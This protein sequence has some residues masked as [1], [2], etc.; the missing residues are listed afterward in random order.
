MVCRI[1]NR[2][3]W[4]R[5]AGFTLLELLV[6]IAIIAVLAGVLLP[7][8]GKAK[9]QAKKVNEISSARQLMLAW[10]MY[11]GDHGDRVIRGYKHFAAGE[12][13]PVDRSGNPVPHPINSRYPW[14][15][16][17][18]LGKSFGVMYA[19]ENAGL[20]RQFEAMPDSF[21]GTYAAS[22]FPSLGINATFVG[23]D[24]LE[25][26]PEQRAFERFGSFCVL[27][28]SDARQPDNL[29]VFSSARGP[30]EGKVVNGFYL[31]KSPYFMARR[32][33]QAFNG[34]DGPEAWGHVHPRFS[35]RAVTGMMDGHVE[36]MN[37][38]QLQ[39]MQHWSNQADRPDWTLTRIR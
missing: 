33:S 23:G 20:L 10:T 6:V 11:A 28:I 12:P 13:L 29:L 14:R 32:W 27:R 38:R 2:R 16:A 25:L 3:P 21:I 7:A 36:A 37:E 1:D 35:R 4:G 18:W 5:S 39:D 24:D 8:V 15:L 9:S 17:P 30:F 31:V 26:P 19:N 34:A 22:V